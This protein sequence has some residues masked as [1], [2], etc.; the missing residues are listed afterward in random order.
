MEEKIIS[1]VSE[2]LGVDEADISI[3]SD[4]REDLD[5]DSIDFAELVMA[6][7]EEYDLTIPE[8]KLQDIKTVKD[9]VDN[10]K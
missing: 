8:D 4:L 1:I 2:V 7:E 6:I 5:G 3:N 9:I 10:L